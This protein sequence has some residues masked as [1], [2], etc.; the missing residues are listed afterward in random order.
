MHKSFLL[1]SV[2]NLS[3][4]TNTSKFSAHYDLLLLSYLVIWMYGT[5]LYFYQLMEVFVFRM[6]FCARLFSVSKERIGKKLV[7]L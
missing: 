1:T 2:L 3:I 5:L 6:R 4:I 7:C